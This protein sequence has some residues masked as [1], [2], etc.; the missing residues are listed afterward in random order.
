MSN[1]I[2]DLV[3]SSLFLRCLL[4]YIL[5]AKSLYFYSRKNTYDSA[6]YICKAKRILDDKLRLPLLE[7][8][9]QYLVKSVVQ[10]DGE[11]KGIA[12][13]KLISSFLQSS[14]AGIMRD[15]FASADDFNRCRL[16][17]PFDDNPQ[18]QGHLA[19]LLESTE[20]S[21]GLIYLQYTD[22]VQ[23]L[24]VNFDVVRLAELYDFIYEPS[25]WGY[26]EVE[27]L[28]LMHSEINVLIQAQDEKDLKIVKRYPDNMQAVALGASDWVDSET[29]SVLGGEKKR[30]D[31]VM[32]ASWLPLKR[33]QLLFAHIAKIL[34]QMPDFKI[35]L[36]G[37]S[38]GGYDSAHILGLAK[39]YGI[40]KH[41]EIFERIPPE[42]VNEILV[43]SKA[44]VMLSKREGANKALSEKLFSGTPVIL[45]AENRGVK[46]ALINA[47]TG[48][49]SE[50]KYLWKSI[51]SVVENCDKY[52]PRQWMLGNSGYLNSMKV[53]KATLNDRFHWE[54]EKL[55]NVAHFYN[56]A[57]FVYADKKSVERFKEEYEK[58]QSYLL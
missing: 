50:D 6:K 17:L 32:V 8:F 29:F 30:Y 1:R 51:L 18:R 48:I 57:D 13:S 15:K 38:W 42:Q 22:S 41:I 12:D 9:Y 21:K 19:V 10:N 7:G 47:A 35:A 55:I 5:F 43:A 3:Y 52:N 2:E 26:Y 33:H 34:P 11:L 54:A 20:S 49:V 24:F 58:L 45:S 53:I 25:T 56:K 23:D 46:R 40:E 27:F 39:T 44:G 36:I 14:D 28:M 37:Y 31:L 16:R 4:C